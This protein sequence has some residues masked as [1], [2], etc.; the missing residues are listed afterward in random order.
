MASAI[1]PLFLERISFVDRCYRRAKP[2]FLGICHV[3]FLEDHFGF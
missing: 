3:L 2:S 1:R